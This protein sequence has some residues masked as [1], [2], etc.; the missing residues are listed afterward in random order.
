M[1][2][3]ILKWEV[4]SKDIYECKNEFFS[5]IKVAKRGRGG[6]TIEVITFKATEMWQ[7]YNLFSVDANSMYLDPCQVVRFFKHHNIENMSDQMLDDFMKKTLNVSENALTR[8]RFY[9][10][11]LAVQQSTLENK[12]P[13]NA[14]GAWEGVSKISRV[15]ISEQAPFY[16][17]AVVK[18]FPCNVRF[19]LNFSMLQ[20][21][22]NT[23]QQ[24]FS[25]KDLFH[26]ILLDMEDKGLFNDYEMKKPKHAPPPPTP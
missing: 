13:L 9:K 21:Y 25:C 2:V 20:F 19:F 11:L 4:C 22:R 14:G 23:G 7:Y 26:P 1:M 18:T 12:F 5:N 17:T 10:E 24:E 8:K 16:I 3:D 6:E 15:H